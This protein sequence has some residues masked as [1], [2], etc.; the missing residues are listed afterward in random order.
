MSTLGQGARS[1]RNPMRELTNGAGHRR[2]VICHALSGVYIRDCSADEL[3]DGLEEL[4]RAI[5]GGS[6][7]VR[8]FPPKFE[9]SVP[10]GD[11]K[12]EVMPIRFRR[13][14]TPKL[15]PVKPGGLVVP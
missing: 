4:A 13:A 5:R 14:D 9:M 3:A 2:W 6:D 15:D 11:G 1:M 10:I 7:E 12:S 8:D